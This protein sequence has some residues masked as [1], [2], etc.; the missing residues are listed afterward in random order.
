MISQTNLIRRKELLVL[1]LWW[2]KLVRQASS[3]WQMVYLLLDVFL[4]THFL[5]REIIENKM[6]INTITY[7]ILHMCQ[8]RDLILPT[9]LWV[10]CLHWSHTH[11]VFS[12]A[13]V[14]SDLLIKSTLNH[15]TRDNEP[16]LIK[17]KTKL[18]YWSETFLSEVVSDPATFLPHLPSL[19]IIESLI[20]RWACHSGKKDAISQ[21]PL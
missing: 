16:P 5:K 1:A 20:F 9:I 2:L 12:E 18:K 3:S 17:N 14:H 11:A 15:K 4:G 19:S 21:T 6:T 7:C 13:R 10:K 8:D